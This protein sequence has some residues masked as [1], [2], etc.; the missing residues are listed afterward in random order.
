MLRSPRHIMDIMV[1]EE[2]NDQCHGLG[3]EATHGARFMR[4]IEAICF[5]SRSR[6]AG[7]PPASGVACG[8]RRFRSAGDASRASGQV[9]VCMPARTRQSCASMA[10]R[11]SAVSREVNSW[12]GR[13]GGFFRGGHTIR[14]RQNGCPCVQ[15]LRSNRKNRYQRIR[16][17][18]FTEV[19]V[20][21]DPRLDC[22][23]FIEI[24]DQRFRILL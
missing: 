1:Q 24:V 16:K 6:A 21:V 22:T 17:V 12:C 19:G 4:P 23:K 7:P 2:P 13:H 11:F 10:I 9:R 14:I 20:V 18:L 5:G 3:V 15:E 8:R